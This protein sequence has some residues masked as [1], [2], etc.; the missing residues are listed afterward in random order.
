MLEIEL[1]NESQLQANQFDKPPEYD[2]IKDSLQRKCTYF[3][4][5]E[6]MI[7]QRNTYDT[8]DSKMLQCQSFPK[9]EDALKKQWQWSRMQ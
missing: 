5:Q 8:T 4:L 6:T 2:C 1:S 7:S 9:K 3:S